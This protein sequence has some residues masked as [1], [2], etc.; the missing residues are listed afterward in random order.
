MPEVEQDLDEASAWYEER[1][2]GSGE[3][4]RN[5]VDAYIRSLRRSPEMRALC[6]KHDRKSPVRKFPHAVYC[7]YSRGK[8]RSTAYSIPRATEGSGED[9]F[10][11][12]P[13]LTA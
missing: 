6:Y 7:R 11:V 12:P 8:S 1:R 10:P 13:P 2:E 9:A 3:D 5:R 4:V